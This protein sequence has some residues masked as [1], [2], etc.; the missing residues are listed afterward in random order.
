M[1]ARWIDLVD[2]TRDE[3]LAALP[4]RVDPEVVEL[5]AS[6][7]RRER[8]ARPVFEGHGGYVFGMLVAAQQ[9][10]GETDVS[11]VEVGLVAT[12]ELL[13][14]VRRPGA[15]GEPFEPVSLHAA[16]ADPHATAGTL[17]H[18]LVDDVADSFLTSVDGMYAALEE[19]EDGIDEWPA[20][21]VRERIA[22]LRKE[23]LRVRWT[24][25]AT[26][27]TLRRILDG[28]VDIGD[29]ELFPPTVE[30]LFA[31]TTEALFRVTEELDIARDLL[32]GVRDHHQSKIAES[33]G[34]IA[35]KL[36]VIASLVLVPSLIVGYYGQ[37]F[38]SAFDDPLWSIG[39][40][41]GL[42]VASSIVQVALFRW[43][44]WI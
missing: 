15:G 33:Q 11:Y 1:G 10:A 40:S 43:R 2:P 12:T 3:L 23:L 27:A 21:R 13:V 44:R 41:S 17:V 7:P 25:S 42:I 20:S 32:A 26:H 16:A 39:V 5:L 37:N 9:A 24:V 30:L 36:T 6:P 19:L 18:R 14:T 34:D 22:A 31:D 4:G 35:K 38:E 28:R 8:E 29:H